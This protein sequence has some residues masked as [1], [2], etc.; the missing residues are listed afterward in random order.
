MG[1]VGGIR[2]SDPPMWFVIGI[3]L[4]HPPMVH[5]MLIEP[6]EF[7]TKDS[8]NTIIVA[9]QGYVRWIL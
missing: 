3:R 1:I 4:S 9:I 8:I 2:L 7:F 6:S 5:S